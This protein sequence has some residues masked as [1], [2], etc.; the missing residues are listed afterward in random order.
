M[1]MYNFPYNDVTNISSMI[2]IVTAF[3]FVTQV[4]NVHV[5]VQK[6]KVFRA[7]QQLGITRSSQFLLVSALT[8]LP[9]AWFYTFFFCLIVYQMIDYEDGASNLFYF[10]HINLSMTIIGVEVTYFMAC[11]FAKEFIVRDMFLLFFFSNVM[12]SG[13]PFPIPVMKPGI[14]DLMGYI[15]MRWT[16]QALM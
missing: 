15:P 14:V 6:L 4:N 5:T 3:C 1:A 8:E 11:F 16:F 7:E 9:F 13:F 10:M 12:L 2:L